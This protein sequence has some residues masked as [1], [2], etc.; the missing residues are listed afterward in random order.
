MSVPLLD[1]DA[2]TEETLFAGL[3]DVLQDDENLSRVVRTWETMDGTTT[4]L[5]APTT[6]QMPHLRLIPG[7]SPLE[8]AEAAAYNLHLTI[9]VLFA[10]EGLNRANQYNLWAA[11]RRALQGTKP[12]RDTTVF[13]YVRSLGAVDL[14]ITT[15][16]F[17]PM[18]RAGADGASRAQNLIGACQ[19]IVLLQPNS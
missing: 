14:K 19:I 8:V 10:C 15:P 11:F 6:V 18:P 13:E 12:F 4:V 1:L 7:G 17:G 16:R 5:E 2:S 3:V 9:D